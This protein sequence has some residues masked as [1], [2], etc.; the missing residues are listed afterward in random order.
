MWNPEP[1]KRSGWYWWRDRDDKYNGLTQIILVGDWPGGGLCVRMH[2][3]ASHSD[4]FTT[5]ELCG[6]EWA[7]PLTPPE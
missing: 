3:K 1:P 5:P 4:G 6:G 2:H 7:G